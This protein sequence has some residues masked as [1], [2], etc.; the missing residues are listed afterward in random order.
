LG[1]NK[2]IGIPERRYSNCVIVLC[3]FAYFTAYL[4]RYNYN[5]C[6]IEIIA[7]YSITRTEAGMVSSFFF[8]PYMIGQAVHAALTRRVNS[9][10]FISAVLVLAGGINF[11]MPFAGPLMGMRILW[12]LN[13]V[14]QSAL[15]PNVVNILT[16]MLPGKRI[17]GGMVLMH[18]T[19]AAGSAGAFL[20]SA[21]CLKWFTWRA[22]FFVPAIILLI[23]GIIWSF[24]MTVIRR[25]LAEDQPLSE[26]KQNSGS[27]RAKRAGPGI[28]MS[29][30]AGGLLFAV[31]A[32]IG[33]GFLRDGITVWLPVY[34][35][36]TF[37]VESAL[38]VFVSIIIPI[39]QIGGAFLAKKIYAVCRGPFFTAMIF[40]G[41]ALISVLTMV[42][43]G[44]NNII[45]TSFCFAV[46]ST[47]MTSVNTA[48]VS[49]FP[50]IFRSRGLTA[51]VSGHVN[52]FV[53]IGSIA[54]ASGFGM[55]ADISGWD[56]V[57]LIMGGASAISA[58]V[59]LA[60]WRQS[61]KVK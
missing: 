45:L 56:A 39:A 7:E 34:M 59:C 35:H 51:F 18:T 57:L 2:I 6:I 22:A 44:R 13:G 9:I 60:G 49:F 26:G 47:M 52:A 37:N 1:R 41:I 17:A 4:G 5:A 55:A 21:A 54:A 3:W 24:G 19:G 14:V 53:Y 23:F 20:V 50:L 15:W 25:K 8:F 58:S 31:I 27:E 40:Y 48:L 61:V 42:L 38:A 16:T 46:C 36:D 12:C 43:G 32:A 33:N 28:F 11:F 10:V 29:L 30:M